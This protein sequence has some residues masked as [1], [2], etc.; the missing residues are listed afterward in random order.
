M[1]T[2]ARNSV[3]QWG[4]RIIVGLEKSAMRSADARARGSGYSGTIR[5]TMQLETA[6]NRAPSLRETWRIASRH[7]PA[8]P[9]CGRPQPPAGAKRA[10]FFNRLKETLGALQLRLLETLAPFL[11][12]CSLLIAK[13]LLHVDGP[14]RRR[15]LF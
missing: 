7:L 3:G 1:A 8:L 6:A 4:K 13:L 15:L 5:E 11:R 14:H 2:K 9:A 10:L 12:S